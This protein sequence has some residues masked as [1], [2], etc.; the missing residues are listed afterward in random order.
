M[1]NPSEKPFELIDDVLNQTR[2]FMESWHNSMTVEK[3]LL[4][5]RYF[6]GEIHLLVH[7]RSGE[8]DEEFVAHIERNFQPPGGTHGVVGL[9]VGLSPAHALNNSV[10]ARSGID[11]AERG[12][13][14]NQKAVLVDIVEFLEDPKSVS[15]PTVVRLD[16]IDDFYRV[17]PR[18]LYLSS[19]LGYVFR[20]TVKDR[21]GDGFDI[22]QAASS[23]PKLHGDVV[24]SASQIVDGVADNEPYG[25]RDIGNLLHKVKGGVLFQVVLG[26]DF[27]WIGTPEGRNGSIKISDVLVGPL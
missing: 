18:T 8:S 14:K 2:E 9:H 25:V 19:S 1:T 12:A 7:W 17:W 21:K 24:Q 27:V 15:V 10:D 16:R 20:G 4:S 22:P 11:G 6:K 3:L 26:A 23:N 5:E 13:D